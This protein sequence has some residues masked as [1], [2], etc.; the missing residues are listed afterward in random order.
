MDEL[1][2]WGQP[3]AW[4]DELISCW[5]VEHISSEWG[6]AMC[7]VDCLSSQWSEPVLL[8]AWLNNIIWSPLAPDTTSYL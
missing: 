2:V 8:Q 3:R 5:V 1:L 4:T 6:Q 7:Q